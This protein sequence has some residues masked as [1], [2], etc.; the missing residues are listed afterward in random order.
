VAPVASLWTCNTCGASERLTVTPDCCSSC[1]G[2]MET[3]DGRSTYAGS[4]DQLNFI[5]SMMGGADAGDLAAIIALWQ[6][7][8]ALPE[9]QRAILDNLLLANRVEL[10]SSSYSFIEKGVA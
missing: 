2:M 6:A 1:G 9:P 3:Q 5:C 7:G 4:S 8:Y 10:M